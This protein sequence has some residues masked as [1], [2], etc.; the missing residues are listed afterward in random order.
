MSLLHRTTVGVVVCSLTVGVAAAPSALGK[1]SASK[2]AAKRSNHK[3][4]ATLTGANEVPTA[5]DPDGRGKA[6]ITIRGTRL[7][8]KIALKRIDTTTMGHIHEGDAGTAGPVVVPLYMGQQRRKGCVTIK[9]SLGKAILADPSGYY[10]NV[11][12]ATYPAG[13]ARGQL[14]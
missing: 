8:Y 9:A 10:V 3:L 4:R 12:N 5:G 6:K 14:R 2:S 1:S 11:H 13:A 7:C